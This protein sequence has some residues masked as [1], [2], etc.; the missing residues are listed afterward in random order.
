MS[1]D[2]IQ[3]YPGPPKQVDF[4]LVGHVLNYVVDE[5][6]PTVEKLTSWLTPRGCLVLSHLNPVNFF[7]ETG[8]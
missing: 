5:F 3:Q 2:Y 1:K 8:M 6:V 7:F 4:I